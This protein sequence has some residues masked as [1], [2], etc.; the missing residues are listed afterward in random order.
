[1]H[2]WFLV[3]PHRVS[4]RGIHLHG[5][6]PWRTTWAQPVTTPQGNVNTQTLLAA[7]PCAYRLQSEISCGK[8]ISHLGLDIQV[9]AIIINKHRN[10]EDQLEKDLLIHWFLT[11]NVSLYILIVLTV[12]LHHYS[13]IKCTYQCINK[14][15]VLWCCSSNKHIFCLFTYSLFYKET[16]FLQ[17]NFQEIPKPDRLWFI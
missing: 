3:H 12:I 7:F 4:W 6:L 9:L 5:C 14:T 17:G 15:G 1:M 11:V 8:H 10:S 13:D 2:T 16:I